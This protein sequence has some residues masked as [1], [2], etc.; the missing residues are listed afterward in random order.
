MQNVCSCVD[1]RLQPGF[2]CAGCI[3]QLDFVVLLLPLADS[4]QDR[5]LGPDRLAHCADDIGGKARPAGQVPP[6]ICI[7]PAIG[8]FPKELI[9][10]ITVRSV[11]FDCIES[12]A[13]CRKRRISEGANGVG[14]VLF[15]HRLAE[16]LLGSRQ[17]GWGV[18]GTGRRP[19]LGAGANGSDMP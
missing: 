8:A 16:L 4:E 1:Q 15:A 10:Q 11:Q 12:E 18:V 3:G 9:N 7:L 14:D 17:A 2:Q 13:L 19:I 5:K 6:P